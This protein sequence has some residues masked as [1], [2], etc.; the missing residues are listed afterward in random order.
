M[1]LE[2]EMWL[3]A[4]LPGTWDQEQSSCGH[5]VLQ[6]AASCP[7]PVN[8][9]SELRLGHST[10]I[11][12]S[13]CALRHTFRLPASGVPGVQ[14]KTDA[15]LAHRHGLWAEGSLGPASAHSSAAWFSTSCLSS[16]AGY[17]RHLCNTDARRSAIYA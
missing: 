7:A 13:Q 12:E 15:Q 2:A 4:L 14:S 9:G 6:G 3:H 10:W 17:R 16:S 1:I 11:S 5:L 8:Q